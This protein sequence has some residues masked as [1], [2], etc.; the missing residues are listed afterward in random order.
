MGNVEVVAA[1]QS[2]AAIIK[3]HLAHKEVGM[4]VDFGSTVSLVEVSVAKAY[5]TI[6]SAPLKDFSWSQRKERRYL[7]SGCTTIPVY[8]ADLNVNNSFVVVQSLI[9]PVFLGIDL[10]QQ[11]NLVLD[12]TTSPVSIVS[13]QIKSDMKLSLPKFLKSLL[14]RVLQE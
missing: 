10:L 12:F 14:N 9:S 6:T 4:K 1:V 13:E 2:S 5:G 11:Y 8:L 3:G 7:F